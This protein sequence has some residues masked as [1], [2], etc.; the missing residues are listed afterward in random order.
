MFRIL[1]T[2][3][4][5]VVIRERKSRG[6]LLYVIVN[7]QEAYEKQKTNRYRYAH[8]P[9]QK[10]CACASKTHRDLHSKSK[11]YEKRQLDLLDILDR[12]PKGGAHH[13]LNAQIPA[14][15]AQEFVANIDAH[16]ADSI[17]V[18]WMGLWVGGRVRMCG[19]GV[20]YWLLM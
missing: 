9:F 18:G 7:H 8:A 19:A 2:R 14:C 5:V 6:T 10:K 13:Q 15:L 17:L 11:F 12:H 3:C 1:R 4:V 16:V 20:V